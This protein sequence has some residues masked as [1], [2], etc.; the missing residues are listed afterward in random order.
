MTMLT[1]AMPVSM[2][3]LVSTR[4]SIEHCRFLYWHRY[5]EM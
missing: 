3:M 5:Q 1:S 2:L 4:D